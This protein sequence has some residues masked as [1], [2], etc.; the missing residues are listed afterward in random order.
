MT[1][2]RRPAPTLPAPTLEEARRRDAADPLAGFAGRFHPVPPGALF[3]NG[4]SLG[5]LPAATA[6]LMEEVV[7]GQ[8]GDRLAQARTQWLDLPRHLGDRMAGVVLGAEP[9]EAVVSDC[10]S[11]NLYKL[12]VAALRARPGRR[13]V[14]VEDDN[15]PTDRYVMAGVAQDA[16][17]EL[18][19]VPADPDLGLDLE[20]LRAALDESVAVV[21]LS[22]VSPRS[23]AL[24]DM[25]AVNEAVHAAG[26]LV[27]WDLSH[28]VGAV[29]LSLTACGTDLAVAS[30]YKHML[31]GPGSP[32]LLYVRRGLQA[33]TTQPV[34]GW[35]GHREQLAMRREYDPDPGIR[36][37][38][39]GS[40]P[41]LSAVAAG[42]GLDL[43]AEAGLERLRAKSVA[44]TGFFQALAETLLVPLGFRL[45]G[46]P[47]PA[48]RGAH[49]TYGHPLARELVPLFA[50]AGV[51]VDHSLPD[52][53][54][55]APVALSTRF[56]EVYE[57][58]HRM[59]RVTQDRMA[60]RTDHREGNRGE[61][62]GSAV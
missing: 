25:A 33:R 61:S 22:L 34:Q 31:A 2:T 35:Y 11:V 4:S 44:L 54:R 46:P 55:I 60:D 28:A 12:A 37:F 16:G 40:P 5:R 57:A 36:R 17:G 13:T 15:F 50:E 23:G 19:T 62:G 59:R 29:P 41:V 30:T 49:L 52:R 21:C 3:L 1:T 18:R 45:A 42:A 6:A 14:V 58:A 27:L 48:A 32:A 38:L 20:V 24:L 9:G 39:T 56:T 8:W 43:L 53:V 47:D 10:T 7:R 26:A 51:F